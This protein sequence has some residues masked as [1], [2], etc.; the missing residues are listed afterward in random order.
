MEII[1]DCIIPYCILDFWPFLERDEKPFLEKAIHQEVRHGLLDAVFLS[2][3]LTHVLRNFPGRYQFWLLL[4]IGWGWY[5]AAS[6]GGY[7]VNRKGQVGVKT[8]V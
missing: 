7:G 5:S 1:L 4:A 6:I 2:V 3:I 8:F